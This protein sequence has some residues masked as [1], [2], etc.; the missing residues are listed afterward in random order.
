MTWK[1][2]EKQ[3]DYGK[4][5]FVYISKPRGL[6]FDVYN[7]SGNSFI[8]TL[9]GKL[10]VWTTNKLGGV[11]KLYKQSFEYLQFELPTELYETFKLHS[12][13]MLFAKDNA[14]IIFEEDLED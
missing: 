10:D 6:S 4:R 1:D 9:L 14:N 2:V 13:K 7:Y 5:N 12:M 8:N 11:P 3:L